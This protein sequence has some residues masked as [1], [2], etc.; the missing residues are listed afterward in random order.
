[1]G[2]ETSG[3][4]PEHGEL[5]SRVEA[6][7]FVSAGAVRISQ[8]AGTLETT[9]HQVEQAL[10][11]LQKTYKNRGIR[12]QTHPDG[13]QL[14]TAPEMA[15]DIERFLELENTARLSRAAMEVLSIIA[16]Q[17]PVTRPYIDSI[18]GVNSDSV[19]RTLLRYG[20]IEEAGRSDGP[21]RPILYKTTGEFL[22]N[23]G[24][25]SLEDLPPLGLDAA[26]EIE[27]TARDEGENQDQERG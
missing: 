15:S 23:F 16:Y 12:L 26:A 25:T 7:L 24:L 2:K 22:L 9:P 18:R 17:E 1:M 6:L 27:S 5:A 10:K 21:G 19:L 4:S 13:V 14:T 3:E 20:L 8:I 11:I